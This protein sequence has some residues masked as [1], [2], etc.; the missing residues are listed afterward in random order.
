MILEVHKT[1]FGQWKVF[2]LGHLEGE[3]FWL[4][5]FRH[6]EHAVAFVDTFGVSFP[7]A[8]GKCDG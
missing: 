6:R 1:W 5:T 8:A 4:G 7:P 2:S 3:Y